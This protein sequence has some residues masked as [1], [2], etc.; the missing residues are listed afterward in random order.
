MRRTTYI[1]L[2]VLL[3]GCGATAVTHDATPASTGQLDPVAAQLHDVSGSLLMFLSGNNRLPATLD[4]LC[5][6]TGL[7]PD[8]VVDPAT[9]KSFAYQPG[10]M[11]TTPDDGTVVLAAAPHTPKGPRWC[12]VIDHSSPTVACRVLNLPATLFER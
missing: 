12:V 1:L 5:T 9:G 7:D 8:R 2:V 4:E 11:A 6:A 3:S 10:G